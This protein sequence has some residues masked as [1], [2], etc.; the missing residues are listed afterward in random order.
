MRAIMNPVIYQW[1]KKVIL[2]THKPF[3]QTS[4]QLQ[5]FPLND[6]MIITEIK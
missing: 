1:E 4:S 6:K 3:S 2:Q 5:A